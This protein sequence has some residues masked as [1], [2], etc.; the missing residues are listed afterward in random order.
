MYVTLSG[1]AAMPSSRVQPLGSV[2]VAGGSLAAGADRRAG[3]RAASV[4]AQPQPIHRGRCLLH[5]RAGGG[6]RI[7][8]AAVRVGLVLP[9]GAGAA[10]S[11]DVGDHEDGAPAEAGARQVAGV[12]EA[13]LQGVLAVTTT[14]TTRM[15]GNRHL[16]VRSNVLL[17]LLKSRNATHFVNMYEGGVDAFSRVR[18]ISLYVY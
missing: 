17:L 2:L 16:M 10:A 11:A 8:A 14:P 3:A 12:R 4:G 5:A 1:L 7:D 6:G 13:L 9:A 15:G 18:I